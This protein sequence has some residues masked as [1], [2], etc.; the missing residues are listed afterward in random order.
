MQPHG[1]WTI[2]QS[3]WIYQ[4]AFVRLRRDDVIR[5]DGKDGTHV[6][7]L[8]KPGVC[9]LPIDQ[10]GD[11]IL[12]NEFHYGIGRYSLEGVSGGIDPGESPDETARR[13]LQE[14][15]GLAADDWQRLTSIDPFTTITVSP[16][17]LYIARQLRSVPHAPEGTETI[18]RATLSLTAAVD[19]VMTGSITH[20]PTCILLLMAQRI[21]P[22]PE[23]RPPV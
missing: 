11:V 22:D 1:P 6:V 3:E 5:P 21:T 18:Q 19:Q 10:S 15:L 7:V 2:K 12:T 23:I 17:Q 4:D 20:G 14:E 13:E 8:Q 16:T 9:V